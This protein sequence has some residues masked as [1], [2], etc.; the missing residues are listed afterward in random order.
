MNT[1]ILPIKETDKP[2]SWVWALVGADEDLHV[3]PVDGHKHVASKDCVCLP[4]IEETDGV[5]S[6][7]HNPM[8]N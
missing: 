2:G 5:E 1:P 7:N 6:I 8:A 3:Y 4:R